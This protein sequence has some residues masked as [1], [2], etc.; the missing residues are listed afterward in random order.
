MVPEKARPDK[1]SK[2]VI[3]TLNR[4]T[5]LCRLREKVQ[6]SN[7]MHKANAPAGWEQKHCE[8][9]LHTKV[10]GQANTPPDVVAVEWR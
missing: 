3:P 8:I 2:P 6:L 5:L 9:L 10:M 4:G 1:N 7:Q